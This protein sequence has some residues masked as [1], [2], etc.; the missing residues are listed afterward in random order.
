MES[1]LA[2]T[3]SDLEILV[4]DDGSTEDIEAALRPLSSDPRLTLLR[5]PH[6]SGGPS[7]PR[8]DGLARARGNL[9]AFLDSDDIWYPEKL[10]LQVAY[11]EAHPECALVAAR[12][13]YVGADHRIWPENGLQNGYRELL[14]QNFIGCSMVLVRAENVRAVGG[15]DPT[16]SYAEDWDLWLRIAQYHPFFVLSDILGDYFVR[17]AEQSRPRWS[18]LR[19]VVQVLT[20]AYDR[21]PAIQAHLAPDL[22][23]ARRALVSE[24]WRAK[25]PLASLLAWLM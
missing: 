2:Q 24:L 20:A 9:V 5:R 22:A 16:V 15:F 4:I 23:A 12:C 3:F 1:A 11:L 6:A 25:K 18:D 21:D 8:N 17:P 14:H 19:G 13:R 10:A 7:I